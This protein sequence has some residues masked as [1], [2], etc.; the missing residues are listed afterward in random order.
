V[1]S[2]YR[3]YLPLFQPPVTYLRGKGKAF[4]FVFV[5]LCCGSG[6]LAAG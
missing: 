6:V 4:V 2:F 5:F 1:E 3:D